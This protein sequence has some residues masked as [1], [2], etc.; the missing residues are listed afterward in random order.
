MIRS[1]NSRTQISRR[2]CLARDAELASARAQ[3]GLLRRGARAEEIT[4]TEA[5]LQQA[6]AELSL[7]T[8]DAE[9]QT[10][11]LGQEMVTKEDAEKAQRDLAVAN[12]KVAAAK[13]RVE[14]VKHR[15]LP[16]ELALAIAKVKL[17][18]AGVMEAQASL[19][20]TTLIAPIDGVIAQV[21]TQEGETV[22]AGMNSPTF[23]TI[24]D[25]D[26]LEVAAIRRRSRYRT[27][28]HRSACDVLPWTR[29]PT[30]ILREK[31]PRCTRERSSNPTWSTTSPRFPSIIQ[32]GG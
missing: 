17:A 21:T 19:S 12:G 29:F 28:C 26:K 4:E 8:T 32:R 10:K 31:S 27:N 20:Y 16:E 6:E 3:L 23:V 24:I 18:E 2:G 5:T 15:Y 14:L 13:S 25:L 30:W 22:A 7:A 9:R 1:P 11:L